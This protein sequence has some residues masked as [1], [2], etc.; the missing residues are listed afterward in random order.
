M[1]E[2]NNLNPNDENVV[3]G[4]EEPIDLIEKNVESLRKRIQALDADN[5]VEVTEDNISIPT[6]SSEE[7]KEVEEKVEDVK[8][9]FEEEKKLLNDSFEDIKATAT[10]VVNDNPKLKSSLDFIKENAMKAVEL[11]KD[12]VEEIKS[13]PRVNEVANKA[14]DN[15]QDFASVA[16]EKTKEAV[17]NLSEAIKPLKE[18]VD[19]FIS[20]PEVQE[21]IDKVKD[22]TISVAN[23]ALETVSDFINSTKNKDN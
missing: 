4:D 5:D 2:K 9:V 16:E 14:S 23:K 11:A 17:S 18:N 1:S 22:T 15:L 8:P 3:R 7:V 19:E 20:K 21:T 6:F 12:K 13:N 10:K